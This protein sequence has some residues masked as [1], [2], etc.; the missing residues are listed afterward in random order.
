MICFGNH[1]HGQEIAAAAGGVYNPYGDIVIS[2]TG[3]NGRLLGGV[4]F[5]DYN[6]KSISIH[7]AGLAPN[8]INTDLIWVT[9]DYPFNQ[10]GVDTIFGPVPSSNIKALE[11]DLRMGFKEIAR[12]PEVFP[13]GDLIV[14]RMRREECKWLNLKPRY[15]RSNC[16]GQVQS[17]PAS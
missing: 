5:S 10:L 14:L 16:V 1:E 8:W 7:I 9:F 4:L 11:F 13:D 17:T 2:R 3:A 15:L 6:K 12:I